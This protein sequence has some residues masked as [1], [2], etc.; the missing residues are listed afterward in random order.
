MNRRRHFSEDQAIEARLAARLGAGLTERAEQ[1]PHDIGE[2]LRAAREQALARAAEVRRR[3]PEPAAARDA[4]AVGVTAQGAVL[5]GGLG[6]PA[7]WQRAASLL[8]LAVLVLGLLLI[9]RQGELEQIH[10]AAE[11]DAQLLADDLPPDAYSDPGFAEFMRER[12]P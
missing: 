5:L 6:A 1:L 11:V 4:A 3:S 7:W 10:A 9:Q 8:P 2:R 12:A